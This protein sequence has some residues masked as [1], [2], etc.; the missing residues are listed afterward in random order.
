MSLSQPTLVKI[1]RD[2]IA[3]SGALSADEQNAM[4]VLDSNFTASG[5]L[6]SEV[7]ALIAAAEDAVTAGNAAV[8]AAT[9]VLEAFAEAEDLTDLDASMAALE[10][11]VSDLTAATSALETASAISP[12]AGS[13]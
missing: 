10:T 1:L 5:Y 13:V 4:S 11:P 12:S 3:R 6:T 8:L 7:A 2:C 9:A